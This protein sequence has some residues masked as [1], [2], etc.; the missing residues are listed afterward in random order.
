MGCRK[1]IALDGCF[2]KKP[3][4]GEILTAIGRDANNHIFPVAWAV[5]N[6]EN[7]DNWSWFLDLLGDDLDM[8]TGNGLTLMSDQHKVSS[9]ITSTWYIKLSSVY[10]VCLIF[11]C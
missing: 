7:K 5:V 9:L 6:V 3:M 2:L 4:V 1:I 10:N 8:P 11:F